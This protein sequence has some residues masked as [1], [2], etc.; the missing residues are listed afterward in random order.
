MTATSAQP[1]SSVAHRSF[2]AAHTRQCSNNYE[3]SDMIL[4]I[5]QLL[6]MINNS[7]GLQSEEPIRYWVFPF[8]KWLINLFA[9]CRLCWTNHI[10]KTEYEVNLG[11][12]QYTSSPRMMQHKLITRTIVH[13]H[14]RPHLTYKKLWN[15]RSTANF[16]NTV[17]SCGHTKTSVYRP[18]TGTAFLKTY[19]FNCPGHFFH[20]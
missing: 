19:L 12:E 9:D 18:G 11:E 20:S 4:S 10:V 15:R 8:A 16:S 3:V 5:L 17:Q 6:L 14:K 1:N 13:A 7:H 2:I